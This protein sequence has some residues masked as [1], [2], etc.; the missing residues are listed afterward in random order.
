[1][2]YSKIIYGIIYRNPRLGNVVFIEAVAQRCSVK[3]E[4]WEIS[5]DSQENICARVFF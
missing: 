2:Q 1:M 5:Q 3:R 4:F